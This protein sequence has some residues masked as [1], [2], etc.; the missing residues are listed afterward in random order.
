MIVFFF[1][2][3]VG[4]IFEPHD[5]HTSTK[6]TA[7]TYGNRQTLHEY[8]ENWINIRKA[9]LA[10]SSH[11]TEYPLIFVLSDGGAS[12]AGYWV[13]SV[14]AKMNEETNGEFNKHLFCMSGASGGSV[15]N[16]A[17]FNLLRA[18]LTSDT[19]KHD[20]SNV[21]QYLK[22]DFLTFTV[23]RMLG[24]D[25]FRHIFP[26]QFVDDRGAALAR[27]LE[28]GPD[29]KCLLYDSMATNFSELITQKNKIYPLPILCINTTRMQD[30]LPAVIS[31]ID[32]S[33][34]RF[35][36][37]LDF[38]DLLDEKK[39]IKLSTAVV[40]G[41]SFP[42]VSP[43]GRI[44]SAG[45]KKKANY[46]V[47]GAY[48][49]NSGSGAV[50]EMVNIL[51]RDSL[52]MQYQNKLKIYILHIANSPLEGVPLQKVNP[53]INDLAAPIKTLLGAYGTQTIVNDNR[54]LNLMKTNF[55]RDNL[56]RKINLY[57]E[58][59]NPNYSMNWVISEKLLKA[60]NEALNRN[61][62][63]KMMVDKLN[64]NK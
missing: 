52:Y 16:A 49:D 63:L 2:F 37:R 58:G 11:Y 18:K 26:F 48:F 6:K 64:S 13:A 29:P 57:E 1:A 55:P 38:L 9:D 24:P 44:D 47:D 30:G 35:N 4:L 56:Y 43:A 8:L 61:K 17:Y 14:M 15:G 23:A 33:D 51:L 60:M 39:D 40:L 27:V 45:I 54:L 25:V 46:F 31:N 36:Q 12:R 42:Y 21:Q 20:V 3:I 62:E 34:P 19:I 28:Q 10:D 50:S 53:M 7:A 59:E 5:I 32:F 41:A 22:T